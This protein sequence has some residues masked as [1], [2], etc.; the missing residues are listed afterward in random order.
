M[1]CAVRDWPAA[2]P[3]RWHDLLSAYVFG[4]HPQ[5][6]CGVADAPCT[7]PAP[8]SVQLGYACVLLLVGAIV[9]A[10]VSV[11]AGV[12]VGDSDG[13]NIGA[14]RSSQS[15]APDTLAPCGTYFASVT[16]LQLSASSAT[17]AL[18]GHG[19]HSPVSRQKYRRV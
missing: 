17:D 7:P 9:G 16:A 14:Q 11:G 19:L 6:F 8:S 18:A 10:G 13:L 3:R 2:A 12:T 1:R 5:P 4:L 15:F